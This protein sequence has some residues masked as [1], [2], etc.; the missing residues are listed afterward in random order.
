[1]KVARSD[2]LPGR[3]STAAAVNRPCWNL[4][5]LHAGTMRSTNG[6]A[7][8]AGGAQV[9]WSG[10]KASCDRHSLHSFRMPKRVEKLAIRSAWANARAMNGA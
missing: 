8:R 6:P 1:M 7:I 5:A 3:D 9:G 4:I 10:D 2:G